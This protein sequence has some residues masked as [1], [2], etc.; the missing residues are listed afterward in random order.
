[1]ERR[2]YYVVTG[3]SDKDDDVTTSCY[4]H[5]D[6]V[7]RNCSSTSI[8][9]AP[10]SFRLLRSYR[11]AERRRRRS[12]AVASRHRNNA[13]VAV[14]TAATPPAIMTSLPVPVVN[15]HDVGPPAEV[16]EE[17][18]YRVVTSAGASRRKIIV[19]FIKRFV[20]FL[21]STVALRVN[22]IINQ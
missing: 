3:D 18:E 19:A 11:S 20:A 7:I 5:N 2:A 17:T 6:D 21:L 13:T 14:T 4:S 16:K 22:E 9:T 10:V 8:G 15:S 1:M 12:K